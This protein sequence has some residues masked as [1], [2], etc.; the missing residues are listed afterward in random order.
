LREEFPANQYYLSA[1][2]ALAAIAGDKE[3]ALDI[4]RQIDEN[5]PRY[6]SGTSFAYRA[7]IAAYLGDKEGAVALLRKAVGLGYAYPEIFGD[8]AWEKL[9]DY[10][11][12]IQLTKPKG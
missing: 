9:K 7:R 8:M 4:S 5:K 3:K 6:R 10:P 12:F 1:I 2:G 11:P